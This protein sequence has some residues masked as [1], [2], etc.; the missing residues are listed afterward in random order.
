MHY[1]ETWDLDSIFAGGIDS[2][3]LTAKMS[4]IKQQLTTTAD[5]LVH[6]RAAADTPDADWFTQ[7]VNSLQAIQAGIDQATV[8]VV[9]YQSA[10]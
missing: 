6:W 10:H 9:A 4:T 5:T 2:P 3:A 7:L 1:S 8:F